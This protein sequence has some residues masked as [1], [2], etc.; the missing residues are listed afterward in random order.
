MKISL[1]RYFYLAL[2]YLP[3]ACFGQTDYLNQPGP[4][5]F[6]NLS[7]NLSW[8]SHPEPNF[9]KQE[10]LVPGENADRFKTMLLLDVITNN[11]NLKDIVNA[12]IEVIKSFQEKNPVV[13]YEVFRNKDDYMID[14]MLSENSPDGKSIY[15][16]ERNVYRYKPF[17]DKTGKEGHPS[18]RGQYAELRQ[19]YRSIPG[20]TEIYPKPAGQ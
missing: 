4:I 8:S 10:Y 14:F 6:D 20:R 17:T 1:P 18:F 3:L 19:G 5:R 2:L 7:Y 13:Q 12:K 15:I 11:P 16:L 9:Y